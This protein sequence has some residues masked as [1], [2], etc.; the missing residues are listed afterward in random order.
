MIG[1]FTHVRFHIF[2]NLWP[3]H[4]ALLSFF[5]KQ[6][7]KNDKSRDSSSLILIPIVLHGWETK[8]TSR[9]GLESLKV[10]KCLIIE[11][12]SRQGSKK[13]IEKNVYSVKLRIWGYILPR[14]WLSEKAIDRFGQL[15]A[16]LRVFCF[17]LTKYS[18]QEG[19][20]KVPST[21]GQQSH[22]QAT[23]SAR[24]APRNAD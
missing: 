10:K 23:L 16:R 8:L 19:E 15:R 6:C 12:E 5:L 24:L 2:S 1:G 7:R 13:K 9:V 22:C 3:W 4:Q 11:R 18:V 21:S 14:K 17:L 20:P